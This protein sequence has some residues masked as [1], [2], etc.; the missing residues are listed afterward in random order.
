MMDKELERF[1]KMVGYKPN[2]DNPKTFNEKLMVKKIYNPNK[3]E[4]LFADKVKVREL[5]PDIFLHKARYSYK[6]EI[7]ITEPCII[8]MNNASGRNKL[9][10]N[11]IKINITKWFNTPYGVENYEWDAIYKYITPAVL[12]ETELLS[13]PHYVYRFF[14]F[15]GEIPLI[16]VYKD[17]IKNNILINN[18]ITT[19]DIKWNKLPWIFKNKP[20]PDVPIPNHF[21]M[22]LDFVKQY[23]FPFCR[24]D[25]FDCKKPI[26]SE[27]TFYPQSA[28]V[29]MD[30]K[31]D[32]LLGDYL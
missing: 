1:K 12:I 6:P 14:T 10:L 32:L 8:K 31:L 30:Y 28:K 9:I 11:P 5:V 15:N 13:F 20:N 16:Q 27:F 17:S 7:E 29:Q 2:L 25:M 4:A 23:K 19:Y 21:D 22:M 3:D 24:I 18:E 26:L